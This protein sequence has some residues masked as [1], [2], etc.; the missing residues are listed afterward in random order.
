MGAY[1]RFGRTEISAGFFL[2]LA[3]L[4]YLDTQRLIMLCILAALI[5]EAAHLLAIWTAGGRVETIRLT[6]VGAEI[7]IDSIT[8]MPY[9]LQ[10]IIFLSGPIVNLILAF[11]SSRVGSMVVSQELFTFAGINL[12]LGLFNLLPAKMMDGGNALRV[13]CL[14]LFGRTTVIVEI[15]HYITLVILLTGCL[16]TALNHGYNLS[17]F[18]VTLWIITRF[19]SERNEKLRGFR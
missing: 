6:A 9:R 15:L 7:M 10:I 5:H 1:I 13:L 19:F 2:M 17:L 8:E 16:V 12:I 11:M 3:V 18:A 14:A 4:I